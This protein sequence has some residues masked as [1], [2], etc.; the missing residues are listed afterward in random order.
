MIGQ[1]RRLQLKVRVGKFRR[2]FVHGAEKYGEARRH[3]ADCFAKSCG[4]I[5]GAIAP[6]GPETRLLPDWAFL[7]SV[8]SATQNRRGQSRRRGG[9]LLSKH[10]SS[11]GEALGSALYSEF[12]RTTN[13]PISKGRW[14]NIMTVCSSPRNIG[15]RV[16]S[17]G[18]ERDHLTDEA[19]NT[20][21]LTNEVDSFVEFESDG[22]VSYPEAFVAKSVSLLIN[23][24]GSLD[25]FKL[26][27]KGS[28][29]EGWYD[30]NN[31][32]IRLYLDF[33]HTQQLLTVMQQP[34]STDQSKVD[35]LDELQRD[36]T[37]YDPSGINIRFDLFDLKYQER[38][39][40]TSYDICRIYI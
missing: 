17:F 12:M 19:R 1:A 18:D 20:W 31:F 40:C 14:Y 32:L 7:K 5:C 36:V 21:S 3:S 16:H 35:I 25:R 8:Y 27:E 4:T 30:G 10:K 6:Y 23:P 33:L 26:R 22:Y 38:T 39:G 15:F 37:G 24:L 29:G 9:V 28:I 13:D 11:T 34:N 2:A